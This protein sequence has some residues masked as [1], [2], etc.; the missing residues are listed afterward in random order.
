MAGTRRSTAKQAKEKAEECREM[1][2]KTTNREHQKMLEDMA[3]AWEQIA[4]GKAM[5]RH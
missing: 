3:K 1:A 5:S 2:R 4:T